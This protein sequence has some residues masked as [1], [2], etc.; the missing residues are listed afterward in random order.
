[1][2]RDFT[3]ISERSGEAGRIGDELLAHAHRMFG[4]WH[5][6]RAGTLSRE[7]FACHML[8]LQDRIEAV[9]QRGGACEETRTANTCRQILQLR[10]A[11]WTFMLARHQ[12]QIGRQVPAAVKVMRVSRL[13]GR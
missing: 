7:H 6:V 12:P 10:Q 11:L 1:M 8:F 9:L 4:F 3:K 5:R 13:S 2:P